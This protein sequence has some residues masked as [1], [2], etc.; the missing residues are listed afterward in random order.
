LANDF[1]VPVQDVKG[2]W[3]KA[4]DGI[5]LQAKWFRVILDEA[6]I[7]KNH[8]ARCSRAASSLRAER[9]W[10]LSGTPIQNKMDD[11][12]SLYRF[13]KIHPYNDYSFFRSN[14]YAGKEL[15]QSGLRRLKVLIR[16]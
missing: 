10:A 7:I 12:Y 11:L 13:L 3:N 16:A 2:E 4:P 15:K 5:L 8:R 14:L 9:R 6:Q 1:S